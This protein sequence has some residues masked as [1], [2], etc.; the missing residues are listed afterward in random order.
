[1]P[2]PGRS[3]GSKVPAI[4]RAA[5]VLD[6]VAQ[7]G[8]PLNLT[9]AARAI[10][11]PKSTVLGICQALV[12]E[13][14]LVRGADGTYWLGPGLAELASAARSLRPVMLRVGLS[15]QSSANAFFA[16][17]IAAARTAAEALGATLSASAA[18]QDLATQV[19]QMAAFIADGVDL[20]MVDPV[21]SLGLETVTS[22]A[23]HAFIPV[24]AI[25]GTAAGADAAVT[26]DNAQ[27]G[28]LI[29]RYLSQLLPRG[30]AIAII[31]GT[32]VT[33]IADRVAGFLGAIRAHRGLRVVSH[34]HGQNTQDSGERAA[35]QV[36]G[37]HPVIDAF[38]AINDPT[39]IGVGRAC[40]DAGRMVPVLSV[41][42][43]AEAV[44]QVRRGGPIVATAAQDPAR[45][46]QTG[47]EIGVALRSGVQP[48]HQTVLLPTRLITGENAKDYLPWG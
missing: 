5:A 26:T 35:R 42:G 2:V 37:E 10:A 41:D 22:R 40:T 23:R 12:A 25:N 7:A 11:A 28:A 27:A 48:G 4:A 38:F 43:S 24:V 6:A 44:A 1:M 20:I 45:L 19:G 47:L 46:A 36:L 8:R 18:E 31:D 17:E 29:G 32:P 14:L 30:G 9:Q 33:A 39:A 13:R 21:A 34:L 15:V 3:A 16:V